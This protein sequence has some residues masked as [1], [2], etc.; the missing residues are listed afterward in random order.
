M[1]LSYSEAVSYL[2]KAQVAPSKLGALKK[3]VGGHFEIR[4]QVQLMF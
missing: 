4:G 3:L 2:S 1:S